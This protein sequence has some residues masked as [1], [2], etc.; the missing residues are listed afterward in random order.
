[1][2]GFVED[3]LTADETIVYKVSQ[4]ILYRTFSILFCMAGVV[5]GAM[6][7]TAPLFGLFIVFL[8][9]IFLSIAAT[10]LAISNKRVIAKFGFIRRSTIEM[11]LERIESIQVRQGIFGRIF[12][13]GSLIIS[14]SGLP[15]APIPGITNPM[16]FRRICMDEQ[17]KASLTK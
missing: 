12:N 6:S 15:M 7:D 2:T 17:E 4:S 9:L 5:F 3:T 8:I 1:M 13:Y 14:G 11:R 10:E 16:K